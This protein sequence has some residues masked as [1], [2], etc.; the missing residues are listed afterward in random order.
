MQQDPFPISTANKKSQEMFL[1]S[2][3]NYLLEPVWV[4]WAVLLTHQQLAICK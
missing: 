4:Y 1:I 3:Q 2:Y